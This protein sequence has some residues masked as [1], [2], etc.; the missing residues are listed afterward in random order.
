M[1]NEM[2]SHLE[3]QPRNKERRIA[4]LKSVDSL[5]NGVG[6]VLLAHFKRIFPLFFQWMHADDDD[7]IILV[8]IFTY[9][10]ALKLHQITNLKFVE[11]FLK[12]ALW[13]WLN[14]TFLRTEP[15]HWLNLQCWIRSIFKIFAVNLTSRGFSTGFHFSLYGFD[16]DKYVFN[17]VLLIFLCQK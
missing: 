17:C 8:S 3:R 12:E 5:L 11:H 10:K 6:L 15:K 13:F 1:L 4:W 2:L 9:R 16:I 14:F 7:T